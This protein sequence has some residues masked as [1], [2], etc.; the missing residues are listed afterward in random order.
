LPVLLDQIQRRASVV[1]GNLPAK[2]NYIHK[3]N[4]L[5]QPEYVAG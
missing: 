4:A 3:I 1:E 2:G 5:L